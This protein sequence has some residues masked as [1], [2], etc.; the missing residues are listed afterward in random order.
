MPPPAGPADRGRRRGSVPAPRLRRRAARKRGT[1]SERNCA[2]FALLLASGS[3]PRE[4]H[5]ITR[6]EPRRLRS[7]PQ[8]D[9]GVRKCA[10]RAFKSSAGP[11]AFPRRALRLSSSVGPCERGRSS[12]VERQLPKLYVEGSIP[13][14]R[15]N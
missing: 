13:F 11:A 9:R 4:T 3:P 10:Q 14:A 5:W 2:C 1:S 12:V 7:P 6:G 15:S 8:E